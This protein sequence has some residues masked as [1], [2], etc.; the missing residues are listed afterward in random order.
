V[1][2]KGFFGGIAAGFMVGIGGAVYLACDNKYIGAVMF[3]VALVAICSLDMCLF[4]GKVGFLVES[5]TKADF[6]L[7]FSGL[8]GNF[9][10]ALLCSLF[11]YLATPSAQEKA[12]LMCA[13]KLE[14]PI[15]AVI[16][17][18]IMCGV[19]MYTAVKV[20]KAKNT[21]IGVVFCVPVFILAGFEHSIAD[22]FYFGISGIYTWRTLLFIVLVIIGNAVG[23]CLLPALAAL[24]GGKKNA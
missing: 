13:A 23:G 17:A 9:V 11:V 24:A 8:L 2:R 4:T 18:G 22:M 7:T 1:L 10:G 3:A 19:L 20:F 12:A 15:A 21:Y 6:A 14:K 16:F 5:H